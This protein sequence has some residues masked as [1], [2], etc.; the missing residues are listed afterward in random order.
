M[1]E[2]NVRILNAAQETK[3]FDGVRRVTIEVDGQEFIFEADAVGLVV[4]R[5]DNILLVMP[6]SQRM[7]HLTGW[8][9]TG[10]K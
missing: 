6:N 5:R 3:K 9:R 4:H 8:G 2:M 7:I 1:N 10:A